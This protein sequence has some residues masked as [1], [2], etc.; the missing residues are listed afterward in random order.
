MAM[1]AFGRRHVSGH[2]EPGGK[3]SFANQCSGISNFA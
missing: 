2:G 1:V 3:T